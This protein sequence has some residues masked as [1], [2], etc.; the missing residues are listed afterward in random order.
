MKKSLILLSLIISFSY[1]VNSQD[2]DGYKMTGLIAGGGKNIQ[3]IGTESS[4]FVDSLFAQFPKT[5]RKGYIWKFKNVLIPG[6]D[7]PLTFQVHQGI[8]GC[9]SQEVNNT[10]SCCTTGYFRTF[11]NEKHK[12]ILLENK[13]I[14]EQVAIIIY[15]KRGRN[16]VIKTE[17]DADLVKKHLLSIYNSAS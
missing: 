12:K 5:K 7:V 6:I 2:T 1:Q 16:H 9:S 10:N 11:S 14:T 4:L 15:L 13:K 8:S 3:I 17:T